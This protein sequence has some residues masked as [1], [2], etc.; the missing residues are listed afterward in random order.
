MKIGVL[1]NGNV[2]GRLANLAK[3]GGHDVRVGSRSGDVSLVDAAAHG[4]IVILA[5]HYHVA[6]DVLTP[7][8]D[9]L[10]GKIL[11]DATNP[12]NDDWSPLLLRQE[13]SAAEE[14]AKLMQGVR[15]VKAFNT[16]FA[17]VMDTSHQDRHGHK[18][19]SFVAGDDPDAVSLVA[20]LA[21]SM[22]FAPVTVTKLAAARYLEAVAHLNIELAVGQGGGTDAAFL[23][24]RG[25]AS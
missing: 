25:G 3:T 13:T 14:I 23:Y 6:S 1:G 19:T 9:A 2:G 10:A 5:V 24:H 18:I 20:E 12:L 21:G 22:G 7:L 11:V 4:D 8:A 17:D 15:V 16:I